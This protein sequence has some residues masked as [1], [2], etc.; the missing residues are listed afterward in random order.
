MNPKTLFDRLL[1]AEHEDDVEQILAEAG[2][3]LD[4]LSVWR[5]LG[6]LE[7]NFSV[8]GNQ[9]SEPTGAMVEKLI[10]S[11]DA[12]LMAECFRRDLDPEG[13]EAPQGMTEAVADFFNVLDGRLE[14]L[15]PTQ[16]TDLAERVHLV[17]VGDKPS[18]SKTPCYLIVDRGEGQTPEQFPETLCSL[19]KSNKLRIPFVQGK[20][21][22]GGTGVLQFCGTKNMQLLASRRNPDAPVKP[23]DTSGDDWGFTLVRRLPPAA[24]RRSS[25][26]VYLAPEGAGPDQPGGVLRFA[27]DGIDVLP[28]QQKKGP[29]KPY[30]AALSHGT[31]VK[32]YNFRWRAKSMATTE[33]RRELEKYLHSPCLPFRLH[34]TRAYNANYFSTTVTGVW[35]GVETDAGKNDDK[36]NVEPGFPAGGELDLPSMGRIPYRLVVFSDRLT[37]KPPHGVFFTINGQVHGELPADFI[38]ARLKFDYLKNTLL[39]SVNCTEM[40]S[41]VRE[42]FFMASR[43]RVR[44]NDVYQELYGALRDEFRDHPGL[45]E[46]NARRRQK[47]IEST[48][49]DDKTT[50]HVFNDL[51]KSDPA[52]KGLFSVGQQLVTTTGPGPLKN[53]EGKRFPTYFRIENEPGKGLVKPVPVNRTARVQFETDAVNDYFDRADCHGRLATE[54]SGLIQRQRLW[55][56]Q[57]NAH[58][59]VPHDAE[60]GQ[61]VRVKVHVADEN[62][63]TSGKPFV[64]E[65]DMKVGEERDD[66]TPPSPNNGRSRTNRPSNNGTGTSSSP[67]LQMPEVR[68]EA[69]DEKPYSALR[70]THDDEGGFDFFI[71]T[72]NTFLLT[73][74]KRAK[75]PERPLL[76][77]WFKYGLTLCALGMLQEDRRR[78]TAA[79]G[80]QDV[81]EDDGDDLQ[82]VMSSADGLSRVIIPVIRALHRGTPD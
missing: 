60:P 41:Q 1:R 25:M 12:V 66:P 79:N 75:E 5:P 81:P 54:P 70:I 14:N 26:Y 50:E 45:R 11:V 35:V 55:N 34:E 39:V 78:R 17:A 20:F 18:G 38:A 56:G 15:Q 44:R 22:S 69:L 63:D 32:L 57:F 7:N 48:V 61:T 73:E 82:K 59:A 74:I 30:A 8:V 6:D 67:V 33:A 62:T 4:D 36:S 53:F 3:G 68:E 10:N 37:K 76:K 52:L 51:L 27:A 65:F 9:Q 77:Y 19:K 64:C 21:N 24:G 31:C 72:K 58:F 46:L 28:E 40:E 43:D 80:D 42:D 13:D 2:Y 47:D 29:S 71:N 49:A 23:G 16:Q